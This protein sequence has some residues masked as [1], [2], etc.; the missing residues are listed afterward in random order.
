MTVFATDIPLL[1]L[2]WVAARARKRQAILNVATSGLIGRGTKAFR[3]NTS[4]KAIACG[5]MLMMAKLRLQ[6]RPASRHE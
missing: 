2:N 3:E 4:D 5:V 6:I 1:R